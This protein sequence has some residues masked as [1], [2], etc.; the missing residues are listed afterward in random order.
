MNLTKDIQQAEDHLRLLL[1][2]QRNE[3]A[4]RRD[5]YQARYPIQR[6]IKAR[7]LDAAWV[8]DCVW[9]RDHVRDEVHCALRLD[10]VV[11]NRELLTAAMD[12]EDYYFWS[13]DDLR[14]KGMTYYRWRGQLHTCGGG[15]HILKLPI[16]CSGAQWAQL[17]EGTVPSSMLRA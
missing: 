9:I 13:D 5:A 1:D 6:G 7:V 10:E 8:S 12:E 3:Y 17:C 15:T 11:L 2:A 4:T 14:S 16:E